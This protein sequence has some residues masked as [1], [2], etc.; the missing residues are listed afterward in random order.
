MQLHRVTGCSIKKCELSKSFIEIRQLI[1]IL[2]V[3]FQLI[4][5]N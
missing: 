3:V 1:G 2:E 4:G 5:G